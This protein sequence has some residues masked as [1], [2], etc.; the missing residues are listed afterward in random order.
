MANDPADA[1]VVQVSGSV[2]AEEVSLQD[3]GWELDA[4][5]YGGIES[6]DHRRSSVTLPVSF[7]N[8]KIRRIF[9]LNDQP[10]QTFS[11]N[12]FQA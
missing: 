4:V 12:F 5:L 9:P 8:L 3:P 10:R 1:A 7:I 2:R 11:L 6:V